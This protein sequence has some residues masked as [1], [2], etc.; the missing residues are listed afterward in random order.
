MVVE[1]TRAFDRAGGLCSFV[2]RWFHAFFCF[3]SQGME[4]KCEGLFDYQLAQREKGEAEFEVDENGNCTM[5]QRV[6]CATLFRE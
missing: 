2:P 3:Y 5:F 1:Q 6:V 4:A